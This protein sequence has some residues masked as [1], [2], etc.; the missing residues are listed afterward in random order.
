MSATRY[1]ILLP[2]RHNDG[3]ELEAQKLLQTK[4]ELVQKFGALT[5]DPHPVESRW[6]RSGVTYEDMLLKFIVDVD[7]DT[8]ETQ[9]FFREHKE[10]LKQRFEQLDV[11]VVA[12]PIRIV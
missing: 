3:R 7:R 4:N 8:D 9:R 12:F 10:Q 6:T 2:L 1:E 5:V 11:W